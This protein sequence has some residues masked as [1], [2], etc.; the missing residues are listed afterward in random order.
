MRII[1][2]TILV[3]FGLVLSI[4]ILVPS[5]F[6][7]NTYKVKLY[8]L[9]E[10]QTSYNL[11]IKGPIGISVF[12]RL[13]LN[14]N[15]IALSNNKEI[16]F[17]AENLT[18]YPSFTSFL[19]G[20]LYFES[21]K[22][23]S[24]LVVVKKNKDKTYNWSVVKL[25]KAKK[26]KKISKEIEPHDKKNKE[27]FFIIK[28]LYLKNSS[29]TYSDTNT[30][31][32]ITDINLNFKQDK[33]Q[34]YSLKGSFVNKDM[35]TTI[36]FIGSNI[37][38]EVSLEG[39]LT[40]KLYELAGAGIY[41]YQLNK[42]KFNI[43]GNIKSKQ[44]LSKVKNLKG[45]DL[46]INAELILNKNILLI[47]KLKILFHDTIFDGSAN[48]NFT[49]KK[50]DIIIKLS[51][52]KVVL[53]KF[54]NIN[55]ASRRGQT[56]SDKSKSK[57]TSNKKKDVKKNINVFEVL[58]KINLDSVIKAK[59][60]IYKDIQL[61]NM[62]VKLNK[63]KN[64]EA[65]L[66]GQNFFKASI[67]SK[68]SLTKKMNFVLNANLS[69]LSLMD[70]NKYYDINLVGGNINISTNLKGKLEKGE[71][72]YKNIYGN[73]LISSKEIIIKN[74]NLK[75]L[76]S[77][78][79]KLDDL[80]KIN[81]VRKALFNGNTSIKDQKINFVHDKETIKIPITRIKIDEGFITTSG[82][83]NINNNNLN[84]ISK[85]ES[86]QNKLLSL[87]SLKT[88]GKISKPLTQISF[89]EGVVKSI[90]EK[91]AQKKLKKVI[92]EKLEEKFDN[93][94]DKLLE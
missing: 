14:A 30:E 78:I 16:L 61:D 28:N 54:L 43:E 56:S 29:L 67:K 79:I 89:D 51:S 58:A 48:L 62:V 33:K 82:N 50:S 76:K 74:F 36:N 69:N 32:T 64:I 45:D 8:Q 20:N 2:Y 25:D 55:Q 4:I 11:E 6:D 22:L 86:D 88:T 38:K 57:G 83:Y 3:T 26:E 60:I 94:I 21:I 5:F 63:K 84:L 47:E 27:S 46:Q 75:A 49:K 70:L 23:E 9:V 7:L 77:D 92:E 90:L 39:D 31:E 41:N 17:K 24:S 18:V 12:P 19:K 71:K 87:F 59:K 44:F 42:G 53:D 52:D 85:Y 1:F 66:E 15:N 37:N 68:L 80:A 73:S 72:V 40:S 93:I 35:K 10:K 91:V 81:D 34:K 65:S 13:K